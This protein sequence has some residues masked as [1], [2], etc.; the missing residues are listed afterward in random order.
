MSVSANRLRVRPDLKWQRTEMGAHVAWIA[1]DPFANEFFHLS[2]RDRSLLQLADGTRSLSEITQECKSLFAPQY[3]SPESVVEFFAEAVRS[4]LLIGSEEGRDAVDDDTDFDDHASPNQTTLQTKASRRWWHEPLAIRLPGI[5]VD[6]AFDRLL[7]CLRAILPLPVRIAA[8]AFTIIMAATAVVYFDQIAMHLDAVTR[9]PVADW[10]VL[11]I[12]VIFGLKLLH[13][14]A[15]AVTCK[16]FGAECR[17]IGVMLLFGMPV[18]YCDVSDAWLQKQRWKRIMVSSAGMMAELF[19]AAIAML[20]WLLLTDSLLRDL[21]VTVMF[22]GSVSTVVFNGNPLLRYDGYYILSDWIGVPNLASQASVSVQTWLRR[23]IWNDALADARI[24]SANRLA[25]H[26]SPARLRIYW[27]A[28]LVYRILVYATLGM[29]VYRQAERVDLGPVVGILLLLVLM[30]GVSRW[31][32]AVLA[33]PPS[34]RRNRLGL[35][36]RPIAIGVIVASVIAAAFWIPLPHRIK[37]PM[38]IGIANSQPIVATSPGRIV[39]G[40]REG[41]LVKQGDVIAKLTNPDLMLSIVEE[42]TRL[43]ALQTELTSLQSVRP[44]TR[45][46]SDRILVVSKSI[47]SSQHQLRL[48]ASEASQLEIVAPASGVVFSA[49]HRVQNIRNTHELRT[50]ESTALAMQNR[51]AWIEAGTEF[52]SLGEPGQYDAIALVRQQDLRYVREG[53][54]VSLML[55]HLSPGAFRGKVV[56]VASSSTDVIPEELAS[57]RMVNPSSRGNGPGVAY[58]QVRVRLRASDQANAHPSRP[59]LAMHSTGY[60]KINV[61]WTSLWERLATTISDAF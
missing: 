54:S 2:E 37:A 60:V 46:I 14:I 38:T 3:V 32:R 20:F 61:P 18:L 59:S 36:R 27:V 21:C 58:Y 52:G 24:E 31:L 33:P 39:D 5:A 17:Q 26:L 48:L 1:K 51:G 34:R 23:L 30:L 50:W 13:E 11:L 55:P 10:G 16:W 40:I 56:E 22:V 29:W 8:I 15:H 43:Q 28:S 12:A 57:K 6:R 9:E 4:G 45:Q 47:D 49:A 53:Q 41:S 42:Q 35:L 7:P 44:T 25:S 19:V